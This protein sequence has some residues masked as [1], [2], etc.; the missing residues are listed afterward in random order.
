MS[1]NL[2]LI[3]LC[4]T[5]GAMYSSLV[6]AAILFSK[7]IFIVGSIAMGI[8]LAVGLIAS[9]IEAYENCKKEIGR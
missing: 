8:F 7:D 5:G 1:N 9:F 4:F 6:W 3:W 2:L